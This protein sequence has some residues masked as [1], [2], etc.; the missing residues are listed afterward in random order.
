MSNF[1]PAGDGRISLAV[2]PSNPQVVYAAAS[3]PSSYGLLYFERSD[4]GGSSW[5][6]LTSGTPNYMGSQGW[7]DQTLIVSLTNSSTVFAGGQVS[8]FGTDNIIEST[9][10]GVS[11]SNINVGLTAT[12]RIPMIM[13]WPSMPTAG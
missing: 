8:V 6:N 11:W 4:N 5:T 10:A 12:A 3:S 7:Y 13:P 2:A 9:N 1:P